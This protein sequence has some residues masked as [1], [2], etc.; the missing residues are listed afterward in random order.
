MRAKIAT[1][2]GYIEFP[3][4]RE[5]RK[6]ARKMG[7]VWAAWGA[8]NQT[9]HHGGGEYWALTT[10]SVDF[11]WYTVGVNFLT[12]GASVWKSAGLRQCGLFVTPC[13]NRGWA[14]KE[15]LTRWVS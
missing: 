4:C 1:E 11:G 7:A 10:G 9:L 6:A 2:R 5:A 8:Q 3:S 13:Y 12:R 15:F 14:T